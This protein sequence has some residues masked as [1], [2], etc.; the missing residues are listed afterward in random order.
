MD[1]FSDFAS[2]LAASPEGVEQRADQ[3][4]EAGQ[5]VDAQVLEVT[6]QWVF[7]DVGSPKDGRIERVEF[8]DQP[9]VNGQSLRATVLNPAP[10]G[11]QLT[12]RLGQRGGSVDVAALQLAQQGGTPVHGEV[13]RAVKAGLEVKVG[14]VTAFCPASQ[15]ELG[16]ASD[17]ESYVGQ[18]HDFKVIELRDDGRSVVLSR[19]QLL[20]DE[21]RVRQSEI[22]ATL[23][24]GSDVTGVVTAIQRHGALIDLSGATGYVHI[25]ELAPHRVERV[26]DVLKEGEQVKARVLSVEP[27]DKGLRIRL[28]LK[29]LAQKMV[30]APRR[31]EILEATVSRALNHGV[32]VDTK[33]GSGFVPLKEL[34]LPPGSDHR[35]ACPVGKGLRVVLLSRDSKDGKL[36][37]SA[38]GVAGV[39]ERNNYKEFSQAQPRSKQGL[40]N[41]GDLLRQKLGLPDAQPEPE[42]VDVSDESTPA[43]AA[44]TAAADIPKAESASEAE[45]A[46]PQA[47]PPSKPKIQDRSDVLGVVRRLKRS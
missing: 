38:I 32:L 24:P 39:E 29:Q 47:Q 13:V 42:A 11:A 41:L 19:K 26:E 37:F 40:G 8:G 16:Y 14:G 1:D 22:L 6:A 5:I 10:D 20:Q 17:L 25:S 9:P 23:K 34:G 36:R 27:G 18:S 44:P 46:P 3:R 4:L 21:Q 31:E 43:K 7:V 28:S 35:R 15:V 30:E 45:P 12:T 33:K 2:L